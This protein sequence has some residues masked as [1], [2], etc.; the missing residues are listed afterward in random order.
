MLGYAGKVPS[1]QRTTAGAAAR[2]KGS[3]ALLLCA[4]FFFSGAAA[5]SFEALWF[6]VMGITL[7]NG[8]WAS[9]IVLASFMAGLSAG[10]ALA[11]RYGKS[12]LRPLQV[13]AVIEVIVGAMGVAIVVLVPHLSAPLGRLFMHA[14][15]HDWVVNLVRLLVAFCLLLVPA[16][17]MGVTLPLLSK[18]TTRSDPNFGRV[19]G[20]LYGWNTLGGVAG[21]L[22]G[23]LWLV[24]PLGLRGTALVSGSLNLAS[25]AVALLLARSVAEST[26]EV[27]RSVSS[28]PLAARSWRLLT[29]AFV[30]GATL[31]SLEVIWFR[32]LQMFVFGTSFIF[33]AMLAAILL[34]IGGGGV[35]AARWLSFD[36]AAH[37][38][39]PFVALLA[40]VTVELS[41]RSFEPRPGAVAY[42]TADTAGALSLFLRL[43]LPTALLSGVLFTLLGA[44]HRKECGE[45][46]EAVGQLTLANTLG[47]MFG[48]A[49]AGFVLL[50]RL[51]MEKALFAAVLSYGLVGWLAMVVSRAAQ[52]SRNGRILVLGAWSAFA[53]AGV[54]YPFGMMRERIIPFVLARYKDAD[55]KLIAMREGLTETVMYLRSSFHGVP[56]HHRLMTNGHSMSA[57]T[58]RGVRYMKLYVY[59]AMAV[60]P[61]ARKALLISYGV[62]NTAKALTDTQQLESIDVVD[63]SRDVLEL[64]ALAF[65]RERP[66]L[67]DP[68][69][70]VHVEDGRFFLQT[71]DERF[72]IITAEPPPL[73]GAGVN[74]LYSFEYF[75]LAHDRLRDGGVIT[76]W[77]PVNE[78]RLSETQAIFRGFCDAF[79]DCSLWT[80]A[81]LQW[82][83][84]G[85]RGARPVSEQQ[86]AAQW[87][88]PVVAP[89][90][91]ALAFEQPESLGATFLADASTLNQWA[92]GSPPLDDDHPARIGSAY[93]SEQN[94]DPIY[95]NWM[96]PGQARE[97]FQS[98]KFIRDVWPDELRKRTTPYFALEGVLDD[99]SVWGRFNPVATLQGILTRSTQHTIPLLLMG[100]EPN[101]QRIALRLYGTG[102]RAADVEF[103]MGA[104]AMSQRDYAAAEQHLALVS[105]GPTKVRAQLLRTLALALLGKLTDARDC[106]NSMPFNTLRPADA[107][108]ADWLAHF[109]RSEQRRK[110]NAEGG[111]GK[112][113]T[114]GLPLNVPSP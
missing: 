31:L 65:P 75:R 114:T 8:F 79:P 22:C 78:L 20:R 76:Y 109:L 45:A 66:P 91:A 86:F 2:S 37:R 33:A 67:S 34:G 81:G 44:A 103:E 58:F 51:G 26:P 40:G 48:S 46:A 1:T 101:I 64:S 82:M 6:R 3:F 19:L 13:Y 38:F 89:E 60:N 47:A 105:E 56:L 41:Y 84:A 112:P 108:C 27:P 104:W 68:R 53:F 24:E 32:L 7:G 90:L 52:P 50:P 36:R 59:W 102:V 4:I 96:D 28:R 113:P 49:L 63:I 10:S 72:D 95:Q 25:A 106:L 74:N 62:G 11:A 70:R 57:T 30:A 77:L 88:D 35:L 85:T 83:L 93:P 110:Q 54:A 100:T 39:T 97:R 69:V 71:T 16:T 12:V 111:G 73:R 29:A 9:N 99:L 43:M 107:A 17:A 15:T 87:Q 55:P 21:A 42:I 80:G 23:E 98:S 18:A 92:E 94:G 14:R 5:V 61:N